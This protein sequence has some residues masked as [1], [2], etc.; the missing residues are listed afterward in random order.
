MLLARHTTTASERMGVL[1]C[2]R[3]PARLNTSEVAA[4]L[5]FQDHDVAIL[6]A[7]R[8]LTPLGK[9]AQNAPK[10][11]ATRQVL[12]RCEDDEWLARA[13][14][15]VSVHWRSKNSARKRISKQE[16]WQY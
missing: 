13:T 7:A 10:Y 3:L 8:L 11:F 4:L 1:N 9:P 14:K 12:E 15:A 6:V 2:R 5:G 16:D